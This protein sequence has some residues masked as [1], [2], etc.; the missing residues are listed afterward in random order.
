MGKLIP[1]CFVAN[2]D[3]VYFLARA[4]R[5]NDKSEQELIALVKS[6]PYPTS[7]QETRWTV[8]STS[9]STMFANWYNDIYESGDLSCTV[10]NNGVFMFIGQ[11]N[12]IGRESYRFDP[13]S[14]KGTN[15]DTFPKNST[16][17]WVRLSL[18]Q[19]N[20]LLPYATSS[21]PFILF[22]VNGKISS[23]NSTTSMPLQGSNSTQFMVQYNLQGKRNANYSL[24]SPTIEY[25]AI[26]SS[27]FTASYKIVNLVSLLS[28]RILL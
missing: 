9:S 27:G 15:Y 12:G 26:D 22:S 19:E 23:D 8:V 16:G 7:I 3:T 11:Y 28:P 10:D 6:D 13:L 18:S 25:V 21:D 14:P 2:S 5:M 20:N 4:V 24:D 1:R 17:E